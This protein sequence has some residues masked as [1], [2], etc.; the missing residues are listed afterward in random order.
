MGLEIFRHQVLKSQGSQWFQPTTLTSPF[1]SEL[2]PKDSCVDGL[3]HNAAV[4][5]GKA[6]RMR[7]DQEGPDLFTALI[8]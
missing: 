5:Q 7:M 4:F 6:L 8:H 2:F 3:V 1:G